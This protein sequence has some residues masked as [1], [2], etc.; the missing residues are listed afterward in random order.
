[1]QVIYKATVTSTSAVMVVP[2]QTTLIW[3]SNSD[4]HVNWAA[5]ILVKALTLNNCLPLV[6]R[7][8]F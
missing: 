5:P 8:V 4:T 7:P 6:I 3:M 2:Y 1:M